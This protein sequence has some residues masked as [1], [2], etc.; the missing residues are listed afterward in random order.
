MAERRPND[1]FD[2]AAADELSRRAPLAARMRP[3][4]L[5]E[6]VGQRHLLAPGAPFRRLVESDRLSSAV[7]F[8]PPGTGK[9]TV[10]RLVAESTAKAF[11]PLS[12][13]S[14]GVRDVR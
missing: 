6:V 14:A 1:L 5:D 11:V 9:T 7:L 10:A 3:R 4:R 2:A 13:T 12:A 8:G